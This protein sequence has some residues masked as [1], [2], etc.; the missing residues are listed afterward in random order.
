MRLKYGLKKTDSN[1]GSFC[2]SKSF[3][4]HH[5]HY[6]DT[7]L[8]YIQFRTLHHRFYTNEKLF[9]MG[10]KNSDQ[11]SFCNSSVDSVEHILIQ[12]QVSRD[13]WSSVRDWIIELGML[14]YNLS[15]SKIIL[16][17]LENALCFNTII[18]LTKKII[19][20]AM[21]EEQ[22]PHIAQVKRR[23]IQTLHKRKRSFI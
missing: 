20:N 8:K 16:G 11:C 10:I 1:I 4:Y 22:R 14:N 18:L 19:Y 2:L 12:C 15:D 7:Y 3:Q 21:K 23:E 6:K 9:K 13:L 5:L 17:D